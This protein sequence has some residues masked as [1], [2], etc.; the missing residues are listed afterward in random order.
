MLTLIVPTYNEAENI[1]EL[2]RAVEAAL[3]ADGWKDFE[4]LVMDD[5]SPDGTAERANRYGGCVRSVNRRGRSRGLSRAVL[6]GFELAKNEFVGVMD[7]DFSHPPA[8]IP[9]LAAALRA[10][11]NL[12]IGTRYVKGGGVESWPTRRRVA[13]RIACWL[14]RPVTRVSD[15]TS[16]L[17]FFRKSILSGIR[18]NPT[19]FKIGLEIFVKS[20]HEGKIAEVPFM[21]VDRRAGDSKLNTGIAVD[22]IRQIISLALE[23]KR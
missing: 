3:H 12:S 19:G 18:L 6:E 4:I 8:V 2:V 11:A 22:Y 13:S 7:A 10:G 1:T 23:R 21:F 17:F 14:A 15:P 20:R 16:G 5:D 9:K